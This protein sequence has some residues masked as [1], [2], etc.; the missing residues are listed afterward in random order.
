MCYSN[1]RY[2]VEDITIHEFAHSLHLLGLSQVYPS[3]TGELAAA[4][5]NARHRNLWGGGHYAM[6]N[7][8]EYWA[9]GVQSYFDCNAPD[10]YAPTNRAQLYTKDRALYDL[11]VKYLGN[12]PWKRPMPCS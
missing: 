6:T 3:F 11:L 12:N 4:Y 8:I 10:H 9:E 1:D 2:R 5:N 7:P